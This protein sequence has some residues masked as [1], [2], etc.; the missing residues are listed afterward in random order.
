MA[1]KNSIPYQKKFT[2]CSLDSHSFTSSLW[3][4]TCS[5]PRYLLSSTLPK[6]KEMDTGKKDRYVGL[7]PVL[8][9]DSI[10]IF[11]KSLNEK[12]KKT[13]PEEED[14]EKE[15]EGEKTELT[16]KERE[17][18]NRQIY[19]LPPLHSLQPNHHSNHRTT[20]SSSSNS[21][22]SSNKNILQYSTTLDKTVLVVSSICAVIGGILNPLIA[23]SFLCP[24]LSSLSSP[25]FFLEE[26]LF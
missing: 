22:N 8:G 1:A 12:M 17:I 20:T 13:N 15:G 6:K 7:T 25:P 18:L 10:L 21:S 3:V 4:A 14:K 11:G 19:G 26:F 24:S 16:E 2:F 9:R 5:L 23:V